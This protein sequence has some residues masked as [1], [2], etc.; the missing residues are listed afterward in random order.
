MVIHSAIIALAVRSPLACWQAGLNRSPRI[1][2]TCHD[3]RLILYKFLSDGV[4]NTIYLK[5]CADPACQEHG[6]ILRLASHRK[7]QAIAAPLGSAL[8]YL[9]LTATA[10]TTAIGAT[11][12]K[13]DPVVQHWLRALVTCQARSYAAVLAAVNTVLQQFAKAFCMQ[14]AQARKPTTSRSQP[15]DN[16]NMSVAAQQAQLHPC[17]PTQTPAAVECDNL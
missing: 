3:S 14:L 11:P 17:H 16:S 6:I 4:M 1:C 7:S 13:A 12:S 10:A 15:P 8:T 2:H 9:L 5:S